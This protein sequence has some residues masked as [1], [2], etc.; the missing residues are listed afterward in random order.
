TPGDA[1]ALCE[2]LNRHFG[3]RLSVQMIDPQRWVASTDADLTVDAEPP[4]ALAGR[5]VSVALPTATSALLNEAQMVLHAHPVNEGLEI[6]INSVWF[7]GA[8]RAPTVPT[9]RWHSVTADDPLVLGLGR[10][11]GVRHR[12]LP[13]SAGAW[14]GRAPEEGRHLVLLDALRIPLALEQTG[15]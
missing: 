9:K 8:G 2:A 6:P 7:W 4:L 1:Q 5:D 10:A 11:A 14:L 13:A 3:S 12:A 15:A